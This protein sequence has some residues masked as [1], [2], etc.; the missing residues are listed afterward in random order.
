MSIKAGDKTKKAIAGRVKAGETQD[1]SKQA[2][3]GYTSPNWR[4]TTRATTN[5]KS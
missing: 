4:H 1:Y 2:T 3:K 5:W